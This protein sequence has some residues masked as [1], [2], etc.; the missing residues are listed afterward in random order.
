MHQLWDCFPFKYPPFVPVLK[1]D[2]LNTPIV[3][4]KFHISRSLPQTMFVATVDTRTFFQGAVQ[5]LVNTCALTASSCLSARRLI[6]YPLAAVV[7][8]L[9]LNLGDHT[10]SEYSVALRTTPCWTTY[11]CK[12]SVGSLRAIEPLVRPFPLARSITHLS[13]IHLSLF[14]LKLGFQISVDD[15]IS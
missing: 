15:S 13:C 14:I 10:C 8:L 12:T 3:D 2:F 4:L 1:A 6:V 7:T 9:S 5:G 11:F